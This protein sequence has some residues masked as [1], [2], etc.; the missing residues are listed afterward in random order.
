MTSKSKKDKIKQ[1]NQRD[2]DLLYDTILSGGTYSDYRSELQDRS[3][4]QEVPQVITEDDILAAWILG[5][6]EESE[7]YAR[8]GHIHQRLN[9]N[10]YRQQFG[11]TWNNPNFNSGSTTS[12]TSS[13]STGSSESIGSGGFDIGSGLSSIATPAGQLVDNTIVNW[14]DTGNYGDWKTDIQGE[15][16]DPLARLAGNIGGVHTDN[17]IE[18][19]KAERLSNDPN[20][21][22]GDTAS[23]LSQ[24]YAYIRDRGPK[25]QEIQTRDWGARVMDNL[26]A[27]GQGA[28]Q[29]AKFGPW[30]ALIGGII[31]GVANIP[32]QIL[33]DQNRKKLN[34]EILKYNIGLDQGLKE[35]DTNLTNSYKM[36]LWNQ[37][38]Q[39]YLNTYSNGGKMKNKL[40]SGGY[41]N[42]HYDYITD[43]LVKVNAG[44]THQENPNE[45]VQTSIAPDGQPNLVEEGETIINNG[46]E[47]AYVFSDRIVA[48]DEILKSHLLPNKFAGKTYADISKEL[49]KIIAEHKNDEISKRTFDEMISRLQQAQEDQKFQ[50]KQDEVEKFLDGLTDEQKEQLEQTMVEETQ[51]EQQAAE[52]QAIAEQQAQE[53]AVQE[54][55]VQP[56]Q[57]PE[58]VAMEQQE[59]QI[60]PSRYD[61]MMGRAQFADAADQGMFQLGGFANRLKKSMTTSAHP[62][63]V[64]WDQVI[65]KSPLFT[66]FGGADS[67]GGSGA[68]GEWGDTDYIKNEPIPAV[69]RSFNEAFAEARH[70]GLDTFRFNGKL[71]STEIDPNYSGPGKKEVELMTPP[72]NVRKVYDNTGVELQ[73]STRVEPYFGQPVGW[74]E[75][76]TIGD[77]TKLEYIGS[78]P[79]WDNKKSKG[80]HLHQENGNVYYINGYDPYYDGAQIYQDDRNWVQRNIYSPIRTYFGNLSQRAPEFTKAVT[81]MTP[82]GAVVDIAED[83]TDNVLAGSM[84]VLTNGPWVRPGGTKGMYMGTKGQKVVNSAQRSTNRANA[85]Y[86]TTKPATKVGTSTESALRASEQAERN[87]NEALRIEQ[88][89]VKRGQLWGY[90]AETG[91]GQRG[92]YSNQV[93]SKPSPSDFDYRYGQ[94]GIEEMF[95]T[96]NDF[97]TPSYL[98][99]L[100]A[101]HP[102]TWNKAM[103]LGSGLTTALGVGIYG[104]TTLDNGDI[105]DENGTV[106]GKQ[107]PN[108]RTVMS[109]QTNWRGQTL[110]D[111]STAISSELPGYERPLR[112]SSSNTT[113]QSNNNIATNR[114][115]TPQRIFNPG[116]I[117]LPESTFN[118]LPVGYEYTNPNDRI[119][120]IS[121]EMADVLGSEEKGIPEPT[122]KEIKEAGW[123][124]RKDGTWYKKESD[125]TT[126]DYSTWL[127]YAPAI[128]SGIQYLSDL[129]GVTNR[130]DFSNADMYQR[131]INNIPSVGFTPLGNY[132]TYSPLDETYQQ[133]VARS[134]Y[135]AARRAI[136]NNASGNASAALAAMDSLNGNMNNTFGDL[137]LQAREYNDKQREVVEQFNANI[138]RINSMMSLS[139]QEKNQAIAAE[140]ARLTYNLANMRE[141]IQNMNDAAKSANENTFYNNLGAIGKENF[142][143][144]MVRKNPAFY[145]TIMSDGSIVYKNGFYDLNKGD[146]DFI[147][148]D[149]EKAQKEQLKKN[150]EDT[151]KKSEDTSSLMSSPLVGRYFSRP[152]FWNGYQYTGG[153]TNN[154]R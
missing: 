18:R 33:E 58:Q 134:Q 37:L 65:N 93:A 51:A 10:L 29:G 73:D 6:D 125:G 143:M 123:K 2:F 23:N 21:A 141:N 102:H 115:N 124:K 5:K 137:A 11:G 152:G 139:A 98:S 135:N 82:V 85:A 154:R 117:T 121:Q 86:H 68:S 38:Q 132:M 109:D 150:S 60:I 118:G 136:Q 113:D 151:Q 142:N 31:G 44:G 108:G 13:P 27:S 145:Y 52:E 34:N 107:L 87:L 26:N 14:L 114:N 41:I 49:D 36:Q 140:K 17:A 80:G 71:Y 146:Q 104:L 149:A 47:D 128:G 62:Q 96:I 76:E 8:G 84:P 69:T 75:R 3:M 24:Y 83:N 138:A 77:K 25:K 91:V 106:V 88:E 89:N 63:I 66:G 19:L 78:E 130:N 94:E 54:Q 101:K 1:G 119:T 103:I 72:M 99:V 56:E 16:I 90:N 32:S 131:S 112:V 79:D 144:Q 64:Y 55:Q 67:F 22:I 129:F 127:R 42:S 30:G 74:T 43:P 122:K 133:N 35:F 12:T 110:Y 70:N 81:N 92:T 97:K 105:V 4:P 46:Q 53:Q 126:T 7:Q 20:F 50:E 100:R 39:P 116:V 147:T 111:D 9:S 15:S 48:D 40:A 153:L 120:T 95:G 28:L 45:G 148:A 57:A 59:E 61:Q